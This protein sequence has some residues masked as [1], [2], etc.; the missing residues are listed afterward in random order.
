M[1]CPEIVNKCFPIDPSSLAKI[2]F[3]LQLSKC[4]PIPEPEIL[5]YSET[6]TT[7]LCVASLSGNI[8]CANLK[9][10]RLETYFL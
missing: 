6:V 5:M 2:V 1:I 9:S 10:F 4:I 3:L 7:T 8:Q